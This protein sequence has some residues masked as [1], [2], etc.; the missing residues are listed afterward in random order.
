MAI[1]NCSATMTVYSY[2]WCLLCVSVAPVAIWC[3]YQ[4]HKQQKKKELLSAP[5]LLYRLT[6]PFY[7]FTILCSISSVLITSSWCTPMPSDPSAQIFVAGYVMFGLSWSFQWMF[8]DIVLFIRLYYSFSGSIYALSKCA[9]FPFIIIYIMFVVFLILNVFT[10]FAGQNF[11]A[12]WL[13]SFAMILL[14]GMVL[15]IYLSTLF[16]VKLY[17]ISKHAAATMPANTAKLSPVQSNSIATSRSEASV[18]SKTKS[19]D[20]STKSAN[21]NGDKNT[22]SAKKN[23]TR[24]DKYFLNLIIK[25]TI[26][27]TVSV[28]TTFVLVLVSIFMSS[29]QDR[30]TYVLIW[31]SL[32][33]MDMST[34]FFCIMFSNTFAA[35]YY[36]I[37]CGFFDRGCRSCCLQLNANKKTNESELVSYVNKTDLTETSI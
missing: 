35:K 9:M 21:A 12:L 3:I 8:L 2:I 14:C 20:T 15:S 11:S 7:I 36:G 34:N 33:L 29:I 24:S 23:S 6:I 37:C 13:L 17:N 28:L 22:T 26:L 5:V 32:I 1:V 19:N 31:D 25:S 18:N 16:I 10:V 30:E 27:V 4:H